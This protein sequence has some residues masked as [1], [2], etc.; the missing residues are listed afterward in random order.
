VAE[1]TVEEIDRLNILQATMLAMQRAVEGLRLKPAKVLI[2]G[3]RIPALPMFAEAIVKGDVKVKAISAASVLAKVHRDRWCCELDQ[4]YPGYHFGKNKGYG[5]AE[6][7]KAL[8][9]LGP[10]PVHR[11]S[12]RPVRELLP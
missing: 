4:Q 10:A 7:L 11:K 9:L 8:R 1:A 12:F 2:D 3:N 5:T 6:H